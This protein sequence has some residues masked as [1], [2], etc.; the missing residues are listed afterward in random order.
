MVVSPWTSGSGNAPDAIRLGEHGES[1]V[2]PPGQ[3]TTFWIAFRAETPLPEPDLPRRIVVRV[4]VAQG[5]EPLTVTIAEPATGRPRWIHPPIESA[6][7]AGVSVLGTPFDEGSF[8]FLRASGKNQ[9]GRYVVLGPSLYLGA[10]GGRLRGE[11]ERTIS[12]CDLGIAFDVSISAFRGRDNSFGPY[13]TYQ[14]VFALDEGR[15]DR[16]AWHGPGAGLQFF[17]RLLEPLV[18]GA[19]P[20]RPPRSL[21]GYSSFTIAYVHL[22]RRGDSGGS[23][24]AMVLFEH[25]LPEL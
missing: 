7:Y 6:S 20:V 12:C 22:F 19:F 16:A 18:A 4:P 13:F 15:P 24:G 14:S 1:I 9:V 11:P 17:T 23:P 8:G 10:R 3:S 2:V 25:T 5:A 21:L